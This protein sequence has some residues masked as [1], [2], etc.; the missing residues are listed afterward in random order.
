MVSSLFQFKTLAQKKSKVKKKGSEWLVV[1]LFQFKT[2]A[3]KKSL[4]KKG[5]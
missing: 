1:S 2:S 4:K 5:S 3:Q